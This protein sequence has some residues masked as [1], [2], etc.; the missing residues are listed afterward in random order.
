MLSHFL[1]E[2]GAHGFV[3]GTRMYPFQHLQLP[4]FFAAY[5]ATCVA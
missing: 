5:M 4:L 1:H 2:P 3:P